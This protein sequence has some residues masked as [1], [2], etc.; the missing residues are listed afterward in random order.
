MAKKQKVEFTRDEQIAKAFK[1]LELYRDSVPDVPLHCRIHVGD[2]LDIGNLEECV[3]VAV[4]EDWKYVVVEKHDY[5]TSY[6]VPYDNGRVIAGCWAWYDVRCKD[7]I[8]QTSF[9][10][11]DAGAKALYHGQR[12]SADINS[13][14]FGALRRGFWCDPNYQRSYV[15]SDA[16]RERLLDSVFRGLTIGEFIFISDRDEDDYRYEILDGQQRLTALIDFVLNKFTYKGFYYNEL[17]VADQDH[18]GNVYATWVELDG[19]YLTPKLK[20]EIFLIV[21]DSGV[22]QSEEHLKKVREFIAIN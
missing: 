11:P 2:E 20:A 21:N 18:F 6:G 5:G 13:L 16:D 10:R 15:W 1:R 9:Y 4:S 12:T 22:P 17:S 19:K 14:L 3:A 7:T 8:K